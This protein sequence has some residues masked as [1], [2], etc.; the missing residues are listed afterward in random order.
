[1][2]LEAFVMIGAPAKIDDVEGLCPSERRSVCENSISCADYD[3]EAFAQEN[4]YEHKQESIL[5]I[6]NKSITKLGP[7]RNCFCESFSL[8]F[9]FFCSLTYG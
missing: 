4:I 3:V 7:D 8:S 6:F 2:N 1:M 9:V 5:H